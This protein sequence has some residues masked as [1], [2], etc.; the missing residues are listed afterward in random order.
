A[1]RLALSAG[2]QGA[3]VIA[4]VPHS[5]GDEAELGAGDVVYAIN[6]GIV[7]SGAGARRVLQT[8][9]PGR[10]ALFLCPRR[11]VARFLQ[12]RTLSGAESGHIKIGD[13]VAICAQGPIGLCATL[14]AKLQGAALI[15][16]IDSVERRLD[17]ARQFG[18][19]VTL[20]INDGDPLQEIK[21][22]TDG[23]GVDV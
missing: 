12:R 22:L 1:A 13:S 4:V 6:G 16:G 20:N 11:G 2:C 10:P 3:V 8:L 9:G 18:A 7:H 15:I 14:G 17:A 23:R 21:R 19:N 5:A